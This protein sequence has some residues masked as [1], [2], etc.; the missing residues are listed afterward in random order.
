MYRDVNIR[1]NEFVGMPCISSGTFQ[2]SVLQ[3]IVSTRKIKTP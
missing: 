1:D 3:A 2:Y